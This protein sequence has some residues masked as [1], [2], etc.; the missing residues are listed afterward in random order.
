M[1]TRRGFLGAM[2]AA[3]AAPAFIKAEI[4]MPVRQIIL[5]PPMTIVPPLSDEMLDNVGRALERSNEVL[6]DAFLK[7]GDIFTISGRYAVGSKLLQ[8]FVVTSEV[9]A[10]STRIDLG[11]ASVPIKPLP[12]HSPK[13]IVPR[14]HGPAPR[15]KW[16]VA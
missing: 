8:Q 6:A 11:L 16:K 7:K 2:L 9:T 3:C 14:Q 5:P 10:D 1:T 12:M 13:L 15:G 4:L